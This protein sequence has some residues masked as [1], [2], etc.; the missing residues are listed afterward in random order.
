M[1]HYTLY[2]K[3]ILNTFS[4]LLYLFITYCYTIVYYKYD[5]ICKRIHCIYNGHLIYMLLSTICIRSQS[6]SK[7]CS[8]SNVHR[9]CSN[10]PY[11]N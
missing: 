10:S 1:Y 11:N 6:T 5:Y 8:T 4:L 9:S 2:I 3:L 7:I